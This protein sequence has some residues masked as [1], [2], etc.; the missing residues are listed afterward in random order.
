MR[1]VPSNPAVLSSGSL[2]G[3]PTSFNI[4]SSLQLGELK[5]PYYQDKPL[6]TT[7]G[8]CSTAPQGMDDDL[9]LVHLLRLKGSMHALSQEAFP[10][11]KR[12]LSTSEDSSSTMTTSSETPKKKTKKTKKKWLP[13]LGPPEAQS[14]IILGQRRAG[15]P[16]VSQANSAKL[17]S[18]TT[19]IRF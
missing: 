11:R 2:R 13:P 12:S 5:A 3:S 17:Y 10:M 4:P 19:G 9:S 8:I 16:W 1:E 6:S 14:A 18:T 15:G 7:F